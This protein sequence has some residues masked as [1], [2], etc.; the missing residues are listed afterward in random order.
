MHEA[1]ADELK[2][3]FTEFLAARARDQNLMLPEPDLEGKALHDAK[4][5]PWVNGMYSKLKF[6]PYTHR[7]Y[8]KMV[9]GPGYLTACQ[10]YE[11]VVRTRVKQ[12]QQQDYTVWM[13]DAQRDKDEQTRI[14]HSQKDWEALGALWCATPQAAV[15]AEADLQMAVATA[16]AESA[17]ADK[18]M[19]ARATAERER[20]DAQA[21]EHVVDVP[22]PA[23]PA[24]QKRKAP[25]SVGA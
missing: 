1:T 16:A 23:M 17:Y 4:N 22:A 20:F 10:R 12:D 9:Y 15:Q 7:E 18:N 2:A 13:A 21:E 11:Q 14:V 24:H 8:P 3:L 25:Q 5:A 19:G 6:P